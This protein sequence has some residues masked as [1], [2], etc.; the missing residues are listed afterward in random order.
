MAMA[1]CSLSS[2]SETYSSVGLGNEENIEDVSFEQPNLEVHKNTIVTDTNQYKHMQITEPVSRDCT[3]TVCEQVPS[4]A[5]EVNKIIYYIMHAI[6]ILQ[7][8]VSTSIRANVPARALGWEDDFK[9]PQQFDI[10]IMAMIEKKQITPKVRNHVVREVLDHC[11]FPTKN[12]Y[13][14]V[15]AKVVQQFPVLADTLVGTGYVSSLITAICIIT[16]TTYL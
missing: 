7:E 12:Q 11:L 3:N 9:I 8:D 5:A 15:T 13:Q 14:V 1:D 4:V 10:E 2:S 6:C 16:L